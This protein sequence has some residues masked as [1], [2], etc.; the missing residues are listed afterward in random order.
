MKLAFSTLGCPEWS[1]DQIIT[2]AQGAG[3]EGVEW[4][5]YQAEMD[6]PN[7]VIF[8]PETRG[9]TRRRFQ[10]AGLEFA[11]LG[12]SV[13]LADP[14]PAA[15]ERE[16]A[17]FTAYTELARFLECPLVRVF[18]GN[19]STGTDREAALPSMAAFLRELGERAAENGVTVVLE[20]HDDFSL[21]IHVAELLR[22]TDHPSVGALWDLHHPYRQGEAPETTVQVLA[23]YLRHTHVKDSREDGRYCL[24]GEGDVPLARMIGLLHKHRYDAWISLEWEK[25]W[26]PEIMPPEE[27]FPQ[28]ARALRELLSP[29]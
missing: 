4:R 21:G 24:M 9:E 23:P 6:L 27:V 13:R 25:R 2:A 1:L 16:K 3:Y 5:G 10:D 8:T 26:H 15:R 7:A 29:G 28:Y 17:S 19:L 18:G 11:C 20:T 22:Q 12:S 14:A